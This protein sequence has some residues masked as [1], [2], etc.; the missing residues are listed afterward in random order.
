ME[1]IGPSF[2]WTG[3]HLSHRTKTGLAV[4]TYGG[5]TGSQIT[6]DYPEG[7]GSETLSSE[8]ELWLLLQHKFLLTI[9]LQNFVLDI[10]LP[11]T[12]STITDEKGKGHRKTQF[13]YK[14]TEDLQGW[15]WLSV[16]TAWLVDT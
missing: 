11:W 15:F 5:T 2:L 4:F 12:G 1:P 10:C 6:L 14:S 13:I 8:F 9:N 16:V 3:H 7:C